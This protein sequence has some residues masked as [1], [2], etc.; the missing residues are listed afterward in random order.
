M[1]LLNFMRI[2]WAQL[3]SFSRFLDGTSSLRHVNCTAQFVVIYKPAEG[4]LGSAMLLMKILGMMK[5]LILVPGV[6]EGHNRELLFNVFLRVLSCFILKLQKVLN[7]KCGWSK[8]L[9]MFVSCVLD[10]VFVLQKCGMLDY[11][12]VL[13]LDYLSFHFLLETLK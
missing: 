1:A 11:V 3:S 10:V 4:A 7:E 5:I 9:K 12:S 6:P 2:T 13:F 8:N